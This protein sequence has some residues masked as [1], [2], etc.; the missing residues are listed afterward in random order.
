MPTA[1]PTFCVIGGGFTGLAGAIALLAQFEQ[2]FRLVIVEPNRELGRGV[3]YG[4]HHPLHLL[5]A[6]VA[7]L[8]VIADRPGDFLSWAFTQLGQG[9]NNAELFEGLAHSFLPRQ[10]FGQYVDERFFEAV[11]GRKDVELDII[12]RE[13]TACRADGTGFRIDI[14]GREPVKADVVFLATAYGRQPGSGLR[15]ALS[16]FQALPFE[17][18]AAAQSLALIGSGLTMVDALLAARRSGFQ[19]VA[20][21]I[22]RHAQL[23]RAHAPKGVG[24]HR[25]TLPPSKRISMLTAAFRL[26]FTAADANAVPWQAVVNGLRPQLQSLWQGLPKREQ[27]RFLRHLRPFFDAHRHRLPMEIH[28]QLKSELAR[29]SAVLLRGRVIEVLRKEN[30]FRLALARGRSA[31]VKAEFDL[32]FDCSGHRPDLGSRLLKSLL[33]LGLATSDPHALGLAVEADGQV[34]GAAG[35]ATPG[36]FALGPLGQGSL[37]EITSVPEIVQQADQ[38]A[39]WV[40]A[41]H[42]SQ[43]ALLEAAR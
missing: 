15:G 14:V 5:N 28:A 30:G 20:T 16:P 4:G 34:V 25:V 22:S 41:Q 43:R 26:A 33:S 18:V 12:N 31:P 1:R 23:P 21:I 36:M 37:W 13:A 8:S 10:L 42:T 11:R 2:P 9:E 17:R 27:A 35:R 38:A 6:R 19:G 29:G 39:R 24:T 3:A 32:A 7:D 40:A